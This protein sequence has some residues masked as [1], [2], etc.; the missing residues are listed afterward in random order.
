[1][2]AKNMHPED[3]KAAV[4]KTGVTLTELALLHGLS[5]SLTRAALRRPQ[6]SGNQVIA[7]YLGR[8]LSE[9][10]PEW[11]DADGNRIPSKSAEKHSRGG[12]AGH[13]QKRRA[14]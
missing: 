14:A 2:P 9:L 12:R 5:E 10:W 8:P 13:G 1:M 7:A 11:F 6:P 4:R 3:I